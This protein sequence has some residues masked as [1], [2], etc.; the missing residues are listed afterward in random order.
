MKTHT[1]QFKENISLIGKQLDSKITYELDGVVQTLTSEQLNSITPTFQG[2][3]LKSVMKELDLDSNI[4]I[5]LGT[6]INYKFGVLIDNAYEYLDF[7][8]YIVYSSEK[9][10][11]YD[12]YKIVCYD[13]MLY[14]MKTNENLGITYPISVRNYI[15][16]LCTKIGLEFKNQNETFANYDKMINEE[17]YV[18]QDY[19]Y[20]DILDELAQ[21][22][23]STICLD[24]NDKVEIRYISNTA[25]DTIDEKFLKDINVNFGQKYGPV[26]SIVLSRSAESDNIYLQDEQSVANNGLCEIKI[27]DNQIMNFNNRSEFLPDILK[28]LDGLEYYLNDFASTG[29]A[30]LELCD[31]YNIKVFDNTYSCVMFND[32]LLVTQGLGENVH[33]DMPEETETDYRK[34]DKED[35]KINSAFLIVDKQLGEI[36]GEVT[37][38]ESKVEDIT[39][40][41]Q[42]ST[43]GNSLYL[44]DALESNALEYH[45]DGKSEQETSVQGKNLFDIIG[46]FKK[47]YGTSVTVNSTVFTLLENGKINIKGTPTKR[48]QLAITT[49]SATSKDIIVPLDSTKTYTF[50]TN[51]NQKSISLYYLDTTDTIKPIYMNGATTK[52]I[53]NAKGI[54]YINID[55]QTL[56]AY[57]A[58]YYFQIEQGT[59]TTYEPF[60]PNSPS[61]DYPSEI[62][63]IPSIRNLFD[64]E[65]ENN[66]IEFVDASGTQHANIEKISN[67]IRVSL[68]TDGTYRYG[69]Y[70]LNDTK[71]M[72]GKT[73]TIS[74]NAMASGSNN[75]TIRIFWRNNTTA[76]LGSEI[77]QLPSTG[78]TFTIP[79]TIPANMTNVVILFYGNLS[80]T[81]VAGD[82][83]DYTNIMLE[84]GPIAHPYVPYGAWAKVKV[85]GKNLLDLSKYTSISI[86]CTTTFENNI[87]T[88][89]VTGR[90]GW[91]GGASKKGTDISLYKS[92]L[93]PVKE[94][95][96]YYLSYNSDFSNNNYITYIDKDFNVIND[97]YIAFNNKH[98]FTTPA[99]TK[100]VMFRFGAVE[101]GTYT[102]SNVQLEEG[103]SATEYEPY[104]EKE[105]L[106]DLNIYDEEGN[107]TGHHEL[108]S[109]GDTKD[110]L[111]IVNGQVVIDKKIDEVVLDGS[112]NYS[113][114]GATVDTGVKAYRTN[115]SI[116]NFKSN[117]SS[118]LISTHFKP[119]INWYSDYSAGQV[120]Q[121]SNNLYFRISEILAPDLATFKTWL[122]N[123]PVT[124]KYVLAEPKQIILP[125]VQIPLFE[126]VNHI[127]L[128]DD[129]ETTTSIKY[130][131]NTPIAQ[132]Y[133]VQQQLDGTNSNLADA[134][135]KIDSANKNYTDLSTNLSNNYY[136]KGQIDN[137]NSSTTERITKV[138]KS[139]ESSITSTQ[140]E[141]MIK[142]AIDTGINRIETTTGYTFDKDGLHTKKS[143]DPRESLVDNTGIY[144]NNGSTNM[145]TAN[146]QGVSATNL[147]AN[148]FIILYPIR[149]Q[150]TTSESD[151]T[152]E[153]LGF[154]YIGA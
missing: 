104:K 100:Y 95:T 17:L 140:A 114:S 131:R 72:L 3:I 102:M 141:L 21:V 138:E 69:G 35:R 41:T 44:E 63:N 137:I 16:S 23:A 70:T 74:C 125:N 116:P 4:D 48:T 34:A 73:Y 19:T 68:I 11:D 107:I 122:S 79:D 147:T 15:K 123:N 133:V 96:E 36:R 119:G 87:L 135:N 85:T 103:T 83:V 50:S 105:I 144:V 53:S 33:T 5:P 40:T 30:Y 10:E 82:Y 130:Y 62:K 143:D 31:R 60:V 86:R 24:K 127:S 56:I 120:Y 7:G 154:F 136:N 37:K 8:N 151:P 20:R 75:G 2:A 25:V 142:Q 29:I 67:G 58:D 109:I 132:D 84:E 121:S 150:K 13:K 76:T 129:L 46:Q 12:S 153:G 110:T 28:K 65:N 152:Q 111:D 66:Y 52:S 14:S 47:L 92:I 78:G 64:Y 101:V 145:L 51:F 134:T 124:V 61:P 71:E 89:N 112:Q 106:I 45:V 6:T 55:I 146:D 80:G 57:D 9:Q 81:G 88:L 59:A 94:N 90:D 117:D 93:T 77:K 118:N 148:N 32:E 98:S 26:N 113:T 99:N 1:N 139:V 91:C 39:T 18:G 22:T 108:C 49:G 115:F 126:G 38:V 128:V 149:Q 27:K 42:T 97:N 54:V 43:G